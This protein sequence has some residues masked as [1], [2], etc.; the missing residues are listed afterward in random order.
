MVHIS[1]CKSLC[2]ILFVFLR[3]GLTEY[4]AQVGFELLILLAQ[5]PL[6]LGLHFK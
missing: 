5:H 3:Q 6:V 1:E 4:I 2:I